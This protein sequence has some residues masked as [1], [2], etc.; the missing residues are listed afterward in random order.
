MDSY[1][2]RIIVGFSWISAFRVLSRGVGF[3]KIVIIARLLV[4]AQFGIFG[5][6]SLSLAF[7]EILTE[8]GINVFLVQEKKDIKE[9]INDAWLVSIIRGVII[10]SFIIFT[11]PF[12]VAFFE[13]PQSI[14]IISLISIV[15]LIKGFINPAEVKFQKEL[16]FNKEFY[17]RSAIFSLDSSVAVIASLIT[18]SAIGLVFGLIAGALLEVV[19]S[20]ILIKPTPTF[21]FNLHKIIK[22]FHKG[23]W[24]TLYGI[25]NYAASRGDS[26]AIGRTVGAGALGIYQMGYT[27][28]TLPISEIA[29]VANRVTFPVYS[30][31]SDDIFRL[32]R[33]F[34][35]TILIVSAAA[36]L[37][38]LVIFFFPK[39]L[40]IFIFGQKWEGTM[41]VLR[42]LA[43]FGVIRA[44][45]G[46][47]SS[48][49]LGIG[50][51]NYVAGMTSLRLI[52][53]LITIAPLTINYGI[54]GASYSVLLSGISEI[55]IVI[56]YV[57]LAFKSNK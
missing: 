22:I 25:L 52:V 17:F 57:R 1:S 38:G 36:V 3:I 13:I 34:K 15:P 20:F 37:V 5:I 23:K 4:P 53:L 42:P 56:Y 11:A 18:H 16:Q 21:K 12:V 55:P 50:K 46:T 29:D 51:Q 32:K 40:F 30:K 28:A 27:I 39:D 8:A 19:L 47:T 54:L 44:I 26:V 31:I 49:F 48:L 45:S 41:I 24:V 43:V 35:K 14:G 9:Y 33:A 7:L 10:A 6:A 2:K